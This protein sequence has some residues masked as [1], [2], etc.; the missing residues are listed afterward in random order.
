VT[1]PERLPE[2]RGHPRGAEPVRQP[3]SR[4]V[5]RRWPVRLAPEAVLLVAA[6]AA[7]TVIR[8]SVQG[9]APVAVARGR[10]ILHLEAVLHLDPEH[11]FNNYLS[12]HPVIAQIADYYYATGH[13]LI[14][15]AVL[16]AAYSRAPHIARRYAAAWFAMNLIGL[17]GFW[18]Y[19]LAP[20]RL[21]PH[22]DF[23]DTVLRFGTWGGWGQ[24]SVAAVSNQYAAMPSLHTGWAVW[25]AVTIWA[26][27]RARW[28]RVLA[29]AYPVLT[30]VV[31]LGTANHYLLDTIAGAA[32]TA[33]GF[34]VAQAGVWLQ[35]RFAGTP[36]LPA[37]GGRGAPTPPSLP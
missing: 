23:V 22:A 13:F 11:A 31:V 6:Y 3:R 20:P 16:V 32:T 5:A 37:T 29:A 36:K 2:V 9:S 7:Y 30:V 24:H 35:A 34:G 12:A 4:R 15:I 21:L 26:L 18:L 1:A 14:T 33:A 8:D 19:A 28:L 17:L 10:A 27:T 25:C